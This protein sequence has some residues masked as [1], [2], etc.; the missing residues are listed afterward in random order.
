MRYQQFTL[1]EFT[2]AA[3]SRGDLV[4]IEFQKQLPFEPKRFFATYNVPP[5]AVRGEHAHI[6]CDQVLF[7]LAGEIRVLLNDGVHTQEFLLDDPT[8]GPYVPKLTWGTQESLNSSSIL[9]VFA[10]HPYEESDYIRSF[11]EFVKFVSQD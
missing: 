7:A 11:D 9:G 1:I 2:F 10:S 6:K 3:D 5:T 8:I 4:A